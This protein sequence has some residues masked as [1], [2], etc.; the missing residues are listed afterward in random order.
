MFDEELGYFEPRPWHQDRLQRPKVWGDDT[1][2]N[3]W[4]PGHPH[5]MPGPKK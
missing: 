2:T 5:D 3:Y 4:G 1:P